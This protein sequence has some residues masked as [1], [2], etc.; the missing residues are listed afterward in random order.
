[1]HH[2]S[3]WYDLIV[4]DGNVNQGLARMMGSIL[5]FIVVFGVIFWLI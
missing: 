5:A 3:D 2:K 1:M 4:G